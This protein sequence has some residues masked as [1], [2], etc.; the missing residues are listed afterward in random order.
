MPHGIAVAHGL[1]IALAKSRDEA[2]MPER[3][4]TRY[5]ETL[6]RYFPALGET[7]MAEVEALMAHD[8]KNTQAGRPAWVLLRDFGNP[9]Y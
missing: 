1:R 8:K 2:G 4:L 3:I 6:K 9:V 5:E 7:D